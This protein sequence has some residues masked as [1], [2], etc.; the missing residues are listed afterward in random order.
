M[1]LP[2]NLA[3]F[4]VAAGAIWWAG[5]RLERLTDAIARRTGLGNAFAGLLL[6]AA[7]TSLPEIA[8]TVT[9]VVGGNVELAVHNLLGGVA[10]Q[11]VV[12]VIA[13]AAGRRGPLTRF[14]PSFGLLMQGVGVVLM[15][16]VAIAGL[17]LASDAQFGVLVGPIG[18]GL[19]PILLTLPVAYLGILRL[20]RSA[21]GSPPWRPV[22][23]P[24]PE[25]TDNEERRYGGSG[26]R[27]GLAFAGFAGLVTAAGWAAATLADTMAQQT[28]L[29]S[30]FVGATLLAAATS[31][32][33]ISTTVAAVRHGNEDLA[34]SNV[35][36]S[37]G[38]DVALLALASV[39]AGDTFTDGAPTSAVF[40]AALGTV[41]TCLYLWGLLE[42][43]DRAVA[44]VVG[45]DSVAV[46]A[47]YLAG[48]G[49]LYGLG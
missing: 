17:A 9:A 6:L 26:K 16:G 48:M 13:D 28:G 14:A 32:P 22:N 27:L 49:A 18:V 43:S 42:R 23:A 21:E 38:V 7:A 15:L 2:L 5:T 12:L 25:E 46:V 35:F 20:T 8:T 1:A 36:G 37:N 11:V 41:L 29:G 34:V 45:I 33:E 39:L 19:N 40:T 10:F 44:R 47:L 24:P 30:G 3:L 31:L 4:A